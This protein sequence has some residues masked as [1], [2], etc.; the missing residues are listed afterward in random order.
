MTSKAKLTF[1]I[2]ASVFLAACTVKNPAPI[3]NQAD[4]SQNETNNAQS[5]NLRELLAMG[6]NQKCTFS[7]SETDE[8]NTRNSTTGTLYISGNKIAEDVQ[9][10]SSDTQ[11]GTVNLKVV[12]DGAYMYSWSPNNQDSGMKFKITETADSAGSDQTNKGQG[13]DMD[14]KMALSCS[15][16]IVDNSKFSIPSDVRFT[17]LNQM[18]EGL[19]NSAGGLPGF[20]TEE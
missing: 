9:V 6:K 2:S 7:I 14:E 3:S 15:N 4:E 16:W 18:M 1:V 5:L 17:D 20:P 19:Q 12:S 8:N 13:L 11:I 10:V